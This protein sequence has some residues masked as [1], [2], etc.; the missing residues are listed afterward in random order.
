MAGENLLCA[1]EL[2]EEQASDQQ[3]R[4]GHRPEREGHIGPVEDCRVETISAA[5]R[6]GELRHTLVAPG[7]SP[8]G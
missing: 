5:Y 7:C 3:M 8:L 6:E 2:F 4:P 1:V